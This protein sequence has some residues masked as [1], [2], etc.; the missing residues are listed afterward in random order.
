MRAFDFENVCPAYYWCDLARVIRDGALI[1]E[2][3]QPEE[4]EYTIYKH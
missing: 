4:G 1:L 2:K 3:Q